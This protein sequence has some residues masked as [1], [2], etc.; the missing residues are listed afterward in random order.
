[1][2]ELGYRLNKAAW[3]K[4]YATEGAR[5]LIHKGFT[6]RAAWEQRR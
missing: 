3:G 2:V 4:G 1:M 5:A 6:A